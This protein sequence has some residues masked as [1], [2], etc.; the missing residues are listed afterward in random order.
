VVNRE[1]GADFDTN[2]FS[3]IPFWDPRME[4]VDMRLRADEPQV[5]TVPGADLVLELATGEEIRVEISTKFRVENIAAELADAGFSVTHT[6]T[7]HADDFA[8]TLARRIR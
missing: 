5:V 8:L 2:G 7:D 1:L 3:Y 6:W 4:R